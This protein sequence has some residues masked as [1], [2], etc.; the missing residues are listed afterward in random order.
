MTAQATRYVQL[1]GALVVL[2]GLAGNKSAH[3][4]APDGNAGTSCLACFGWADDARHLRGPALPHAD[5][6]EEGRADG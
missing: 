4:F 6:Y 2:G 5:Q 1:P 3:P